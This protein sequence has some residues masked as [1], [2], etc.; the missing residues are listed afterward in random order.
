MPETTRAKE[1]VG[2]MDFSSM[3]MIL[4]SALFLKIR[5]LMKGKLKLTLNKMLVNTSSRLEEAFDR[6]DSYFY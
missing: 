3:W 4:S 2:G 5:S 6:N 1:L